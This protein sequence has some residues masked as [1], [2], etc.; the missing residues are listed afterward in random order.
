M[1]VT[2]HIKPSPCPACGHVMDAAT[3]VFDDVTPKPG[4]A[5]VCI[6]CAALLQ[7]ADDLSYK[8]ANT[9]ELPLDALE[10]LADVQAAVRKM[11]RAKGPQSA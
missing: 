8:P 5:T 4:D 6:N 2:T 3:A 1:V 7:F 9:H 11:H 10:Q